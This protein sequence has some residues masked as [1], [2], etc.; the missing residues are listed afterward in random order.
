MIIRK[1]NKQVKLSKGGSP[2]FSVLIQ[3]DEYSDG[4]GNLRWISGF[5]NKDTWNW[6]VGD[7]VLPEITE[8]GKYLNFAFNDNKENALSYY[9]VAVSVGFMKDYIDFHLNS[10]G[11]TAKVVPRP[12][13][14]APS[15]PAKQDEDLPF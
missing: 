4:K 14:P 2:F 8:N 1:I 15:Q 7:D 10:G 6:K 13:T 9:E 3:L 12:A 11:R 5:G